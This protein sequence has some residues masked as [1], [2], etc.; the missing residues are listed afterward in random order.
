MYLKVYLKVYLYR[1]GL[2][3]YKYVNIKIP[4]KDCKGIY[5]YCDSDK[6]IT[7]SKSADKLIGDSFKLQLRTKINGKSGKKTYTF[8]KKS[9]TFLKALEYVAGKREEVREL[10]KTQGSL[11]AP[12]IKEVEVKKTETFI[13]RVEKFMEAK[14]ISAR[15]ATIQNYSTTLN[16]HSKPLHDKAIEEI[17]LDDIQMIIADLNAKRAPATVVL[18]ARTLAVFLKKKK[19]PVHKEWEELELPEV[20]NEVEY[21][22]KLSDTKKIISAMRN[23]SGTNVGGEVFYQHEEIRNI[24]AFL[25]TGRRINEVLGLKYKDID[26]KKKTF[27]ISPLRAKGKKKLVFNLDSFLIKAIQSQA[28][29]SEIDLDSLTEDQADRKIFKYTKETPRIH[30]Q[31]LLKSLKL[32]KLRLH[33]IRHMIASTLLQNK[34]PIADIS[35]MLGH[36]SIAITEARYASKNKSQATRA[37]NALNKL[38]EG[39]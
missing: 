35:V 5:L 25:L 34:V 36:S 24:F 27:T 29:L 31:N 22:L 4:N 9:K 13:Q 1:K 18:Y 7:T 10:L 6:V 23:Y 28:E 20:D 33:D 16:T 14:E 8:T 19:A 37:T 15:P 2:Q 39:K 11:V 17:I 21:V 32:P 12:K 26:L 3:M 38:M 30:F